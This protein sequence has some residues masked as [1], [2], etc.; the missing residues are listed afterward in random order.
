MKK[1]KSQ[2][3][4]SNGQFDEKS[5]AEVIR[6]VREEREA[7]KDIVCDIIDS[8]ADLSRYQKFKRRRAV[9]KAKILFRAIDVLFAEAQNTCPYINKHNARTVSEEKNIVYDE[10]L[11]DMGKFD[12]YR[13]ADAR[14][15]LPAIVL[16]HGGGFTAGDKKY[17][18]GR[19]RFFVLH[20]FAVFAVN[21]GL[22]PD[23]LFPQ[24]LEHLVKA[25]NFIHAN[26]ERFNI[27]PE[28]IAVG[29]DSAGGYYAA[30][31][32]SFNCT[33]E[34]KNRLGF[35]LDF[36]VFG[37]LLNCGVYD[38]DT[39]LDTKYPFRIDEGILLSLTGIRSG[40]FHR[41]EYG[42]ICVPVRFVNKKFPPTFVIYSPHD[43]FCAGQGE[44][45]T[46]KLTEAGV[47]CEYYA[48]KDMFSNHCFS[49]TWTSNDAVAA[50]SRIAD[51]A[52]RLAQGKIK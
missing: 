28:R 21:Y 37:A 42:D 25:A 14:E 26:A 15:K 43:T 13:P 10:S 50:N 8:R 4:S 35:S 32:A 17:R 51:F 9:R 3:N 44:L 48:A 12:F 23:Y 1:Q 16:I 29:G 36:K 27:D 33:D 18:R 5:D 40:D 20:G 22:A 24:P 6:R 31:L 47:T 49:L 30:M 39:V 19:S 7:N 11:G 38:I 46:E 41:Y 2:Q 45:L 52:K 34:L